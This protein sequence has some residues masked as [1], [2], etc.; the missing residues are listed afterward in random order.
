M[1]DEGTPAPE[2]TQDQPTPAPSAEDKAPERDA[3]TFA[4]TFDPASLDESLVPAYK[5]MQADYTRKT[6]EIAALRQ[7]DAVADYLRTL[8]ED[9][10]ASVLRSIGIELEADE[11]EED[12][13]DYDD[14]D[15]ELRAQIEE[16]NEWR[17]SQEQ[18]AADAQLE[19][20][21]NDEIGNQLDQLETA[22]GREFDESEVMEIGQI[23]LDRALASGQAPDVKAIY[24]SIYTNLLPH[25]RK[26]WVKSKRTPQAPN[27]AS[28][29]HQ[30]DLDDKEERREFIAQQLMGD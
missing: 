8:P 15:E 10:Q 5:Q 29:S 12:D 30:P 21:L 22:T 23:A 27:G 2:A 9:Q 11:V 26:R 18:H 25:E 13:L 16:I 7:P 20:W 4:G 14:P 17:S 6:Q 19:N 3:N 28:A 1:P 24:E